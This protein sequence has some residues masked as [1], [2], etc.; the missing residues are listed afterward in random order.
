VVAADTAY[1][2]PVETIEP[3]DESSDTYA[4]S[5]RQPPLLEPAPS[6]PAA[7]FADAVGPGHPVRVFLAAAI[8]G[9]LLLV[10]FM[11]LLGLLLTRVILH[12]HAVSAWDASASRWL[13]GTRTPT[14]VDLSWVGS[15]LAGGVV[16]PI[17]VGGL[18]LLFVLHRRWRLAAFTLFVICIESGAYRA[19]SLVIH[20]DRPDVHRLETLPV[21]ASYPSGHTAASIALFGGLLLVLASRVESLALRIMLWSLVIVIPAFVIWARLLRGMHHVTD[22]AAGVIL[23]ILALCITVFAARAAGAAA[24]RRDGLEA[25]GAQR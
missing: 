1:A 15:T 16:I 2:E 22:T 3:P 4:A 17:L 18:L 25:E 10:T 11:V 23:G 7:R 14:L 21:N 12:I 6:G 13:A 24:A 20:R 8:G 9:Y 5:R 19:T